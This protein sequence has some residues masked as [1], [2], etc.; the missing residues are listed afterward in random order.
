M[1]RSTTRPQ[2]FLTL[3]FFFTKFTKIRESDSIMTS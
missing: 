1:H 3:V 2:F